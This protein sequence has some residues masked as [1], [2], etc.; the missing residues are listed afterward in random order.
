[1]PKL[2]NWSITTSCQNN[3]M[4]PELM[5]RRLHGNI[6]DSPNFKDGD[7]INTSNLKE[8]NFK[9]KTSKTNSG[10]IYELGEMD[11]EY[12]GYLIENNI[13]LDDLKYNN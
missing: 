6:Y 1:M 7:S 9:N 3:F 4:A 13:N 12:E 10:T 2:E 11:K 5:Q 8:F